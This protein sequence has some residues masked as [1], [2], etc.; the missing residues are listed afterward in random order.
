M[1]SGWLD[2]P[3]HHSMSFR[4]LSV[5]GGIDEPRKTRLK[6]MTGLTLGRLRV[7][8]RVAVEN[9]GRKDQARW[10]CVCECGGE[11]IVPGH[12]LRSGSQK[13]CGCYRRD[14]A[15]QLYRKHGK[16]KTPEYCMFYD[17]RKRAQLLGL[18]FS[19]EPE[20]IVIPSYCPV[21]GI[22]LQSRGPRDNR[23]SLGRIIP[24]RGYVPTNIRVISFRANR[25]KS[26]ASATELRAVLEYVEAA[27]CDT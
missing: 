7:M 27:S 8:E 2:V 24:D 17:A 3:R 19:I 5:C 22:A 23:P 13:S 15:G 14:R 21:L 11:I 16:S 26:D 25:I 18:P 9:R 6:D 10:K 4:Y 1:L 20:Q 12:R